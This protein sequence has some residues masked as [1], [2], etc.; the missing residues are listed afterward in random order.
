MQCEGL[1][2][3]TKETLCVDR[4]AF[5]YG[6]DVRMESWKRCDPRNDTS[7]CICS[8]GCVFDSC[9]YSK[10]RGVL[11]VDWIRG[12]FA[13]KEILAEDIFSPT[14]NPKFWAQLENFVIS[15]ACGTV[16]G[17]FALRF[18]GNSN[19]PRFAIS[20]AF[21]IR[22][23]ALV[24]WYMNYGSLAQGAGGCTDLRTGF[25]KFSYSQ[26][27]GTSWQLVDNFNTRAVFRYAM[28]TYVGS[29]QFR[30]WATHVIIRNSFSR[31]VAHF[32][33]CA[34]TSETL[35][36]SPWPPLLYQAAST[37]PSSSGIR[38]PQLPLGYV[39]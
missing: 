9:L 30:S 27:G 13:A 1:F 17:E 33:V 23:G 34:V 26:D 31:C 14:Y 36:G 38:M 3:Q 16:R 11:G 20:N 22:D 10:S 4:N 21:P 12:E 24:E 19:L 15:K 29:Q 28:T 8:Q 37:T 35:S 18:R 5:L 32:D 39:L 6:T 2:S 7:G 25:V